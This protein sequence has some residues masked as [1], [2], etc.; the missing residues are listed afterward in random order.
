MYVRAL[1]VPYIY[2]NVVPGGSYYVH[3]AM[4]STRV[5]KSNITHYYEILVLCKT[6]FFFISTKVVTFCIKYPCTL[7]IM[8]HTDGVLFIRDHYRT[9]CGHGRKRTESTT[10][11]L[12]RRTYTRAMNVR[13]V[14]LL[15]ERGTRSERNVSEPYGCGG[16]KAKY[17]PS[18]S[19]K[20]DRI[21]WQRVSFVFTLI[22][23][24]KKNLLRCRDLL[25]EKRI[26]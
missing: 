13:T 12:R 5:H 7:T 3:Y 19:I 14:F 17:E 2:I 18:N 15:F 22:L 6:F 24:L 20:R 4:F 26:F 21:Y 16:L 25:E 10:T 11:P 1:C 23:L 9:M 8:Y